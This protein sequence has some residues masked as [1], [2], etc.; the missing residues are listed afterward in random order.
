MKAS[1]IIQL[2]LGIFIGLFRFSIYFWRITEFHDDFLQYLEFFELDEFLSVINLILG[3]VIIF[4]GLFIKNHVMRFIYSMFA[5]VLLIISLYFLLDFITD[6][7]FWMEL[8]ELAL[9]QIINF[10]VIVSLSLMVG[11]AF[12]KNS[13]TVDII[14]IISWIPLFFG[15]LYFIFII[16]PYTVE[17]GLEIRFISYLSFFDFTAGFLLIIPLSLISYNIPKQESLVQEDSYH[18]LQISDTKYCQ[19]CGTPTNMDTIICSNCNTI[20]PKLRSQYESSNNSVLYGLLGFCIPI[21]GLI[22]YITLKDSQPE[23]AKSS[24]I[25]ALVS[26]AISF[27]LFAIGLII[28]FMSEFF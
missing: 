27:I 16:Y 19:K 11:I 12:V 14:K 8:T 22:L 10:T 9:L 21:V 28:V 15:I 4:I 1:S 26:A 7:P 20:F 23:N 5:A 18:P 13:N 24:G 3:V 6:I 25:G 17:Y 2:I